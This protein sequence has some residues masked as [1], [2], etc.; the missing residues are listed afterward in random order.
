MLIAT[1]R[2]ITVKLPNQSNALLIALHIVRLLSYINSFHT[3]LINQSNLSASIS[4]RKRK[5][6]I[7]L[8]TRR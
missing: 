7:K 4:A 1:P 5:G 2:Y 8:T 3:N 6:Y